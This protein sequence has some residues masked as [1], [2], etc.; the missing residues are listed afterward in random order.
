MQLPKTVD[1]LGQTYLV[2]SSINL[3]D[4]KRKVDGLCMPGSKIIQI[5]V[6]LDKDQKS[7]TFLHECL[8]ALLYE[9]GYEAI[10]GNEKTE[11]GLVL[12]LEHGIKH[13]LIRHGLALLRGLKK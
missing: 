13:L 6:D 5:E 4:G 1:I 10:I 12:A 3:Y 9:S 7:A 2:K 11:E 8:H